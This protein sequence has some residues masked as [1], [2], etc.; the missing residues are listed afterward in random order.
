MAQFLG[1]RVTDENELERCFVQFP[2]IFSSGILFIW[3]L[4]VANAKEARVR[5]RV[6]AMENAPKKDFLAE[7]MA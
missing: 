3:D 6:R 1:V 4:I 7:K 2:S 5:V